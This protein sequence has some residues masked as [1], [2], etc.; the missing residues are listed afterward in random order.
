M[1][2]G[3]KHIPGGMIDPSVLPY[4]QNKKLGRLTQW[5]F[6]PAHQ[7]LTI[8]R[9]HALI[10]QQI[11]WLS[12]VI[13]GHCYYYGVPGNLRNL[14]RFKYELTRAWYRALCR[15]SQKKRINWQKFGQFLGNQ[16]PPVH[17]VH[18]YPEERFYAKYSR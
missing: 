17:T 12:S 1:T 7:H 4:R 10:S 2:P 11:E 3:S 6:L 14:T 8:S 15:C 18:P 5:D 16:L 13:Q 9:R